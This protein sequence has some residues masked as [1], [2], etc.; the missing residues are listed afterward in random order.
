MNVGLG[1]GRARSLL[2]H[3]EAVSLFWG[4][5]GGRRDRFWGVFG[6]RRDHWEGSFWGETRSLVRMGGAIVNWGV[7]GERPYRW[8][9]SFWGDARSG[10]G[11]FLGGGAIVLGG[12]TRSFFWEFLGRGAIVGWG[13]GGRRD[14]WLGD[15]EARSCVEI[16]MIFLRHAAR[17]APA[18]AAP[19]AI[20]LSPPKKPALIA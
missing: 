5:F 2:G 6:G 3:G 1:M 9:G 13:D 7:S 19:A 16:Y 8:E 18:V 17:T 20:A 15:G 11:E 4:V 10:F 12:E 14:R